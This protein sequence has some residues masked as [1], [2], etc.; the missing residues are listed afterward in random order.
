[1][2]SLPLYRFLFPFRSCS[3]SGS[4]S[5]SRSYSRSYSGFRIPDS[6]FS[7]RPSNGSLFVRFDLVRLKFVSFRQSM[8]YTTH[9]SYNQYNAVQNLEKELSQNMLGQC[10]RVEIIE[11]ASMPCHALCTSKSGSKSFTEAIP[12]Q[13]P[14]FL[15]IPANGKNVFKTNYILTVSKL[16]SSK[17][18]S[19]EAVEVLL[20]LNLPGSQVMRTEFWDRH[21]VMQI[22]GCHSFTPLRSN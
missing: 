18:I 4:C 15:V 22:S 14:V 11:L 8:R 21:G 5:Y 20:A 16:I 6:R 9:I 7:R 2:L 12:F 13:L 1:M 3:G 19:L 17:K 10:K